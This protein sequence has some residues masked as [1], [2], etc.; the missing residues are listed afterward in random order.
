MN[1]KVRLIA[2]LAVLIIVGSVIATFLAR[3][4]ASMMFD[5]RDGTR[6]EIVRVSFS[7]NHVAHFGTTLQKALFKIAGGRLSQKWVGHLM[8]TPSQDGTNGNLGIFVRHHHGPGDH[9]VNAFHNLKIKPVSQPRKEHSMFLSSGHGEFGLWEL[10]Y[11]NEDY[12]NFLIENSKGEVV[13][14][15]KIIKDERGRYGIVPFDVSKTNG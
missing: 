3:E 14:G 5:L 9:A 2:S 11:W 8:M 10:N 7:T 12:S 15:F 6:L 1:R 4:P 13:G